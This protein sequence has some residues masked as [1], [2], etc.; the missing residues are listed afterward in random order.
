MDKIR[1][2][3]EIPKDSEVKYEMNKATGVIEVNRVLKVKYPFN[4]GFVPETLWADGD[5]L[6]VIL[7][8]T[9]SLHPGVELMATPK[10]LVKMFDNGESDYKLVCA[11]GDEE[12][13]DYKEVIL[14]FL[15]TYKKGVQI[16]GCTTS[17]VEMTNALKTAKSLLASEKNKPYRYVVVY[18]PKSGDVW[19]AK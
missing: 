15:K 19:E 11:L 7:I 3:I 17:K 18:R 16:K 13:S 2:K 10:A 6:D 14:G 12:F 8:G 1:V 5:P 9:Y 4:Y